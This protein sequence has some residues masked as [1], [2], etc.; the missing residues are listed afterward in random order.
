MSKSNKDKA[1]QAGDHLRA[2]REHGR[3]AKKIFEEIGDPD[4]I[5]KSSSVE[6]VAQDAEEYIDSKIDKKS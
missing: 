6:K 5:K 4:G 1:Q 3:R 2:A